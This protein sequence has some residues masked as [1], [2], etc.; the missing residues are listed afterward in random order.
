MF[1]PHGELAEECARDRVLVREAIRCNG[2][3][4]S[5]NLVFI[6]PAL[7]RNC[8]P[9]LNPLDR[10]GKRDSDETREVLAQY[11]TGAFAS[12]LSKGDVKLSFNMEA[13]LTPMLTV[14]LTISATGDQMTLFDL[15]RFL[16]DGQ[17]VDLVQYGAEK[18]KNQGMNEFFRETF[19]ES[20][21]APTKF[22]LRV[23]LSRLLNSRMF[24]RLLCQKRSTWDLETLMN[25]GKTI[26]I[27]G[28]LA[29][30]GREVTE[31][32]GR[33]ITALAQSYAFLRARNRGK[34]YCPV[35]FVIDEAASCISADVDTILT[36]TR[37]F[38]LHLMLC[39][40]MVKQGGMSQE[41]HDLIQG[42]T[43]LKIVGNAGFSTKK[44]MATEMELPVT[45]LSTL[46]VGSFVVKAD[47]RKA[48]RIQLPD[49]WLNGGQQCS[50][51]DWKMV[52]EMMLERY[53]PGKTSVRSKTTQQKSCRPPPRRKPPR[54]KFGAIPLVL[55]FSFF[56][57]P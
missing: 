7:R 40:Q 38:G 14:L 13:L 25:A 32:Y 55:F 37:K 27:D 39:Q 10:H 51:Q 42:N 21:L 28:S 46:S 54:P 49:F 48:R 35:F 26:L 4:R 29:H 6:S 3:K 52:T 9:A 53:Y 16:Q 36:Q 22:S 1:D 45:D 8:I 23:K 56:S 33:T 15:L 44:A 18:L 20:Q 43:A 34:K 31:I 11:L 17:N 19:H 2:T 47:G 30:L 5:P 24:V 50:E 41:L 57:L 12:M